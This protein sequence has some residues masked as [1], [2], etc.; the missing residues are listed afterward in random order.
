MLL[1]GFSFFFFN[2]TATPEIYTLSLHDALPISTQE[3]QYWILRG[4]VQRQRLDEDVDRILQL[5]NDH[6]YIQA[7]VESHDVTV[8]RENARVTINIVVVEGSQHRVA[9]VGVTCL[10]PIPGIQLRRHDKPQ[11]GYA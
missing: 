5:Y 6:G 11:A 9:S 7:R 4:T 3:R 10:A 2:D 1:C 8:D